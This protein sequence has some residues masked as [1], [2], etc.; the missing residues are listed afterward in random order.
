MFE[1]LTALALDHFVRKGVGL[2]WLGVGMG[3]RLDST[4]VARPAVEVVSR[5]ALD[6]QAYLGD[7][8]E[9]IAAEKAAIIRSGTAVSARQEPGAESVI[10]RRA[11]EAGVP[12]LLEGRDLHS[13][14]RPSGLDGLCLGLHGPGFTFDDV[15]LALLRVFQAGNTPP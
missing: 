6:H 15:P 14:V 11:A 3:G 7:T 2:A 10:V 5:I 1:A 8:I 4:T 13:P 9:K 12:L